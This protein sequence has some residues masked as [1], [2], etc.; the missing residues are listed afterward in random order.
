MIHL[1]RLNM[2]WHFLHVCTLDVSFTLLFFS[3]IFWPFSLLSSSIAIITAAANWQHRWDFYF[4]QP[5]L[6]GKV[7]K[8]NP[9][10]FLISN[11]WNDSHES[12]P[13]E[14]SMLIKKIVDIFGQL[15]SA[16]CLKV[17]AQI[18]I[19]HLVPMVIFLYSFLGIGLHTVVSKVLILEPKHR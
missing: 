16:L 19:Q 7:L 8:S 2:F 17:T 9:L 13:S 10:Y 5:S 12:R 11:H 3:V 14:C 1:K 4:F 15:R 18:L 6:H